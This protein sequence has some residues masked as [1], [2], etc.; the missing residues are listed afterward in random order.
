MGVPIKIPQP[1]GLTIQMLFQQNYFSIPLYQRNYSWKKNEILD[2]WQDLDDLIEERRDNHFFGQIVT[3]NHDNI[4]DLIDGQQRMTTSTIFFAVIRDLAKELQKDNPNLTQD[5][6][7]TLRDIT[8]NVDNRLIR[9]NADDQDTL[10]L[11]SSSESDRELQDY[12]YKRTH[13]RDIQY[14]DSNQK[15]EPMKNMDA[16]YDEFKHHI[17]RSLNKETTLV[18]RINLLDLLLTTFIEKFYIVM[19]SAPTQRDAFIIFETLN[20]RGS[21]LKPS[22]IIKNHIMFLLEDDL[23]QTNLMWTKISDQLN[24]DTGRITSYIRAYWMGTHRS[25]TEGALYRSLS[26]NLTSK[27]DGKIFL[28][29]LVELVHAYDVLENPWSPVANRDLFKNNN[30]HNEIDILEKMNVKLYYPLFLSMRKQR[31]DERQIAQVLHQVISTFVRHRTILNYGTNTLENGFSSA[32]LKINNGELTTVDNINNE[33]KKNSLLHSNSDILAAAS[34]LSKD[35]GKRGQKKWSLTYLLSELS[36]AYTE[37]NYYETVFKEDNYEL[38]H[39]SE[40][41]NDIDTDHENRIGNWTLIEK[42][43]QFEKRNFDEKYQALRGSQFKG[44]DKLAEIFKQGWN[45]DTVDARQSE[46][47]NKINNIWQ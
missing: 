4:Q 12:F 14:L 24:A 26:Q 2:F 35:G 40:L 13:S 10:T 32:A 18:E 9:G 8:R 25:V 37:E 20:S 38:V 29:D 3:F 43:Y 15:T 41:N 28:N 36:Y 6:R 16:A 17:L 33:L 22:D 39:I 45:N 30:L 34:V 27:K 11:Q 31:F 5:A 42:S 21:D 7:D 1:S 23:E 44:N 19:I 46:M 47:S